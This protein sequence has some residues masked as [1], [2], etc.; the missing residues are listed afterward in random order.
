M[1]DV[2]V[3]HIL[4][5]A[6]PGA[7]PAVS[8]AYGTLKGDIDGA[9]YTHGNTT[10]GPQTGRHPDSD[11]LD[12]ADINAADNACFNYIWD[13]NNLVWDRE[14]R[15]APADDTPATSVEGRTVQS[16]L[17]AFD[18]TNY[19]RLRTIDINLTDMSPPPSVGILNV[20]AVL[21]GYQASGNKIVRLQSD[22]T[23]GDNRNGQVGALNI[24]SCLY[25]SNGTNY[26]RVRSDGNDNDAKVVLT[27]GV[28]ETN[29]YLMGFNGA[30]WDRIKS[31][32]NNNDA[33]TP[34]GLGLLKSNSYLMG[35]NGVSFDRII[36]AGTASDNVPTEV[37]GALQISSFLMGFD[38]TAW[39]RIRSNGN[40][41]DAVSETTLGNI[42][43]NNFGMVWNGT[44]WMRDWKN[45]DFNPVTNNNVGTSSTSILAASDT[46]RYLLIQNHHTTN[47]IYI[48]FGAAATTTGLEIP[49][50]GNY[51]PLTPP[52]DEIFAIADGATTTY[53]I[54]TT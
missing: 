38:G 1:S 24:Q 33:A 5:T 15:S 3:I 30:T 51:E 22:T 28:V 8:E 2:T 36:T 47:S 41:S 35:F 11:G 53:T 4:Y 49:P 13:S 25:A 6:D 19:D 31:E 27:L 32:G 48:N 40:D 37:R 34:V 43:S 20:G 12:P 50:G 7:T 44:N 17:M 46:R 54:V 10:V 18:G 14:R 29:S 23:A 21:Y 16:I 42:N 26:D 9:I 52:T 39:D 45:A